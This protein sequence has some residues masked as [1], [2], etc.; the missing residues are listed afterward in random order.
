VVAGGA[1][2]GGVL[3]LAGE[4]E[5]RDV[6]APVYAA[7]GL[8]WDPATA[9]SVAGSLGAP[10]TGAGGH[11]RLA[12]ELLDALRSELAL[13]FELQRASLDAET[14]RMAEELRAS[15]TPRPR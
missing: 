9:G 14:L 13:D 8:A 10:T 5:I 4:R 1:H 2:V 6:L 15:H 3:V 11:E 7:L 12:R